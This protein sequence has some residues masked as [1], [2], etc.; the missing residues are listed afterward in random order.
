[1]PH[2]N[3]MRP[4][5]LLLFL[6]L[7]IPFM[8]N[9]QSTPPKMGNG[10]WNADR[11]S[12]GIA[13]LPQKEKEAVV[14]VYYARA[15]GWRR[16][17]G[18]H[19]WISTKEKNA[20]HYTVYQVMGWLK[21]R[22]KPVVS[23]ENDLPDRHWFDEK[24]HLLFSAIGKDA[25][26]MIPQ[27]R[28]ASKSYNY[29]DTYVIWPGPNSNSYISHIIRNTSGIRIEL[30]PSAIGKD[31]IDDGKFFARSESKTG[32]QLSLFGLLGVTIGKAEGLEINLLGLTFGVD[33]FRPAFKLPFIG[34]LGVDDKPV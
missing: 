18:V 10:W 24:P 27:I 14:Q 9:A 21:R 25:E 33:I 4:L 23:V 17:F 7:F 1:M 29:P 32:Y 19:S 16:Y 31:W 30:P 3:R 5:I 6:L 2:L 15:Y 11:S 13:P 8:A 12:A 22:G 34:R 20:D 26:K 28:K